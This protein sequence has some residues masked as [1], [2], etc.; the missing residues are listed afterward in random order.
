MNRK[1]ITLLA[2]LIAVILAGTLLLRTPRVSAAVRAALVETVLP[3][4][5]FHDSAALSTS[6]VTMGPSTG[7]LGITNITLTNPSS[8]VQLVYFFEPSLS[9]GTC[10]G[11]GPF[12]TGAAGP[13]SEVYVQPRTTVSLNYPTPLVYGPVNGPACL[14]AVAANSVSV[15]IDVTGFVN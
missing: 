6:Y 7:S 12:V 10:S 8:A 3:S 2:S 5:P 11:G 14:A 4:Q 15:W 9:S 13:L 1:N